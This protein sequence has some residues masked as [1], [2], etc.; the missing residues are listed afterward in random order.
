MQDQTA[1]ALAVVRA[2]QFELTACPEQADLYQL[3][4]G[5]DD[6][7]LRLSLAWLTLRHA[8]EEIVG[9]PKSRRHPV[10][11]VDMDTMAGMVCDAYVTADGAEE[12][13]A[14][15][16]A[17]VSGELRAAR[18]VDA[19]LEVYGAAEAARR[20]VIRVADFQELFP[21]VTLRALGRTVR[22]ALAAGPGPG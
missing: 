8:L 9:T 21:D 17:W 14:E 11:C 3:L 2:M 1:A 20:C 12:A 18:P 7:R 15:I 19:Y 13:P 4:L 10:G 5:V 22:E 6:E 16:Y